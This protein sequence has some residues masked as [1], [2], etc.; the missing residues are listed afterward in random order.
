[1][2]AAG[3]WMAISPVTCAQHTAWTV[4]ALGLARP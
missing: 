4:K 1:L 2:A 3:L